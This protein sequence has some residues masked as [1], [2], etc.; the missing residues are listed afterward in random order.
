MLGCMEWRR[1][2]YIS[3]E[4]WRGIGRICGHHWEEIGG[5]GEGEQYCV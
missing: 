1:S 5:G 3:I 4:R 2:K